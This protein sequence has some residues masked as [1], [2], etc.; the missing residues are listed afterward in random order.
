MVSSGRVLKVITQRG[1][2]MKRF[3]QVA[4]LATIWSINS[5]AQTQAQ[6]INQNEWMQYH[7]YYSSMGQP[8]SANQGQP[9]YSNAGQSS[10]TGINNFL[11]QHYINQSNQL[12]LPNVATSNRASQQT[13]VPGSSYNNN[14]SISSATSFYQQ[15]HMVNGLR[16]K[17]T[18]YRS[19]QHLCPTALHVPARASAIIWYLCFVSGLSVSVKVKKPATKHKSHLYACLFFDHFGKETC[20]SAIHLVPISE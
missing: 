15:T 13:L 14:R 20:H 7:P 1:Y 16:M 12:A 19:P 11:T 9:P 3:L 6:S 8:S 18:P 10:N 2:N 5:T 4:C 17:V